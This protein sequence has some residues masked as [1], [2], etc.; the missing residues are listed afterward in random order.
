[1]RVTDPEMKI[2]GGQAVQDDRN[3][4]RPDLVGHIYGLHVE[5][6][7]KAGEYPTDDQKREITLVRQTGALAFLIVHKRTGSEETRGYYIVMPE[8]VRMFSYKTRA[9]WIKLETIHYPGP[10]GKDKTVLNLHPLNQFILAQAA[11]LVQY[12]TQ[13]PETK[14]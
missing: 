8:A 1:M 3:K 12:L 2:V 6:E 13:P 10:D 4:G 5:I 9:G 7:L 11:S 14:S